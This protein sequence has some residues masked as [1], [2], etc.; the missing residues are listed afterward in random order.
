M[1]LWDRPDILENYARKIKFPELEERRK[2]ARRKIETEF[3]EPLLALFQRLPV[4]EDFSGNLEITLDAAKVAID[5]HLDLSP[6]QDQALSEI[7]ERLIPWRKG[8]FSIFGHEIDAEWRSDFKWERLRPMPGALSNKRVADVGCS[9][10]YYMFRMAPQEAECI[11]GFDPSERGYFAF[12]LFQRFI[13]RPELGFELLGIEDL[14]L[15]PKFFDIIYC[16][17]VLYH[18]RDPLGALSLLRDALKPGGH[19]II[20]SQVIESDL[21]CALIPPDRYG[22]ARNVYFVPSLS[23]FQAM[24]QR[25]R[26]VE[27]ELISVTEITEEEQRQTPLSPSESLIDFLDPN[28][29]KKTVEGLPAPLRAAF[30]CRVRK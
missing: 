3:W 25:M 18:Q 14:D 15:F 28:D 23:G 17:G 26:F 16:L 10:A 27:V 12:E 4:A 1:L 19:L 24:L 11:I 5:S 22:K 13:Q 20:E 30:S 8:P 6:E 7:I 2:L 21:P 9:N 29:A